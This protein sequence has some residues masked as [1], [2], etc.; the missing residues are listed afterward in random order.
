[1][2]STMCRPENVTVILVCMVAH[3]AVVAHEGE[4]RGGVLEDGEKNVVISA[5]VEREGIAEFR[6]RS[7]YQEEETK[8]RILRPSVRL[9]E[10]RWRTLYLLPVE[11][12]ERCA[13][14]DGLREARRLK[15]ADRFQCLCVQPAF[16]RMPW[17]ADHPR[18]PLRRYETYFL[19]VVVPFVERTFPVEPRARGRWL[20]GFSK[21]GYGAMS[22]LLRHPELFDRAAAWDLPALQAHPDQFQMAEVF[23]TDENF[24]QYRLPELAVRQRRHFTARPRFVLT[25]YSLFRKQHQEWHR[26]LTAAGITHLYRDGPERKH[27][28]ETGWLEEAIPLLAELP[29]EPEAPPARE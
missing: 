8:I 6:V 25:G 26:Q 16:V 22:L 13:Y 3:F 11:P 27:R 18:D 14:G 19:R 9:G 12:G 10:K 7:P 1:M 5:E 20:A 28:W 4:S 15:L 29:A 17:L 2:S 24:A 21:G 23:G